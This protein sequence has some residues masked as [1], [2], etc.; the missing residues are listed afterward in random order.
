MEPVAS[1]VTIQKGFILIEDTGLPHFWP[2]L[3]RE[4]KK[5]STI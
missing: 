4:E 2:T 1:S 5:L 3:Y